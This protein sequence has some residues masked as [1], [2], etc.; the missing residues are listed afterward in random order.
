[1]LEIKNLSKVFTQGDSGR[2]TVLDQLNFQVKPAQWLSVTGPSGSGKSTLLA[3]MAGLDIPTIGEVLFN[4]QALSGLNED[5]RADFRAK[6]FSFVFQSFRL[7]PTMTALE[8]VQLPLE[9]LNQEDS[10]ERAK[11]ILERVG[12]ADRALH[13]PNELSGGEQQRVAVARAFVSRPKILFADEPTGNL[14]SKSGSKVLQ[15]LKDL[16]S[17]EGSSLIVVTHDPQVAE[18][19]DA[20]LKLKDGKI[21]D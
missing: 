7:M 8:N 13:F 18:L 9:L 14:D 15:L 5:E 17:E 20:T 2:L 6:N 3:I 12:L 19:G 1:M 16:Q 4:N 21:V 10:Q 11:A